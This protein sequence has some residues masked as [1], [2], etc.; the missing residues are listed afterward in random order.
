V[1]TT[2]ICI[3]VTIIIGRMFDGLHRILCRP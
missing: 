1:C 3:N 2:V